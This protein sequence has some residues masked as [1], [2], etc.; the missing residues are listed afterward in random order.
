[1]SDG[2]PGESNLLQMNKYSCGPTADFAIRAGLAAVWQAKIMQKRVENLESRLDNVI[3][4]RGITE[5]WQKSCDSALWRAKE[6]RADLD[7]CED[8]CTRRRRECKNYRETLAQIREITDPDTDTA[9][10]PMAAI[11]EVLENIDG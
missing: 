8:E 4:I 7:H 9:Q 11:R 6:L 10:P 1:M 3:Y 2:V 5:D